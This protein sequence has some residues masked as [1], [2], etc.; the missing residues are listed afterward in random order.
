MKKLIALTLASL[1]LLTG[2]S[3][4]PKT[5]GN[6]TTPTP[7]AAAT[8]ADVIVVGAGGAGMTAAIEAANAGKSVIVIE[9]AAMTGG[10]TTRSTGGMNAANT[11]EQDKNEFTEGAGVEKMLAS[12]KESY[13]DL[14]DLVATVEAQWEEYQAN[15]TGYFDTE[16]LFML[17]TLVGGKNLNDHALVEV[18]ANEAKNGIE[19]LKT[20][21]ADLSQVGSF[22]GASVKRIHKPVNDE[23]KTVAVGSYLVPKLTKA[24]EGKGIQFVMETAATELVVTDGKVTGVKAGE[25]TYT[26]KAVVLA[27]GGFAANTE[28]VLQY[29]PDYEGFVC[30]NAPGMTGDGIVM[31]Q[32]IGADTVD[33]NRFRSIRQFLRK[34]A[35]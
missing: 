21:D 11:P 33:M 29:K 9:K 14:A 13:P 20:V 6:E 16:E 28:M 35:L 24:A 17:D 4:A 2:C 30:T 22:G 25:T 10:N 15:P 31:A 34:P 7:E 19:W 1:M 27:T 23:G 26:G 18:L 3:S 8:E 5:E 32:A 12:A